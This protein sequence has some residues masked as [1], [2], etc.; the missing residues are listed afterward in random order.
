[1][2]EEMPTFGGIR[3]DPHDRR[4]LEQQ[5]R[6]VKASHAGASK[7]TVVAQVAKAENKQQCSRGIPRGGFNKN[8]C[9]RQQRAFGGRPCKG[10]PFC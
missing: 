1:M 5:R 7:A 2:E 3:M 8:G 4:K 10:C 6:Q 9:V